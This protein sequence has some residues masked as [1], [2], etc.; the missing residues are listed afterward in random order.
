MWKWNGEKIKRR[1][2]LENS[3]YNK[4]EIRGGGGVE[5]QICIN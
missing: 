1:K 5:H 2:A 3:L 4:V